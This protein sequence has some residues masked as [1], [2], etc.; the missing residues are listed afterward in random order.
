MKWKKNPYLFSAD[1]REKKKLLKS[2]F[3]IRKLLLVG[4]FHAQVFSTPGLVDPILNKPSLHYT[5]KFILE[6]NNIREWQLD[7]LPAQ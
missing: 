4:I 5:K 3:Q 2:V 1:G 7:N 6:Y